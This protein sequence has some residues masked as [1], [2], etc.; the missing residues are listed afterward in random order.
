MAGEQAAKRKLIA[1]RLKERMTALALTQERLA[2][3]TGV[4]QS[5]V[6]RWLKG[7]DAPSG[8]RLQAL[9]VALETTAD[10]LSGG[11]NVGVSPDRRRIITEV[12]AGMLSMFEAVARGEPPQAMALDDGDSI[13]LPRLTA[14]EWARQLELIRP[15][16]D[17]LAGGDWQA[18][19]P[20]DRQ[21]LVERLVDY[22][23]RHSDRKPPEACA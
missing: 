17:E 23:L 21:V 11:P 6:S 22:Y 14:A 7:Q 4:T 2:E 3:L 19:A 12:A 9:A 20:A 10:Y 13:P 18:L 5:T 1:A 15:V 16:F 8:V